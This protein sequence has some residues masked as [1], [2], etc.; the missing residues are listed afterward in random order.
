MKMANCRSERVRG[1][2]RQLAAEAQQRRNHHLYLLFSCVAVAYHRGLDL[3]G[4]ILMNGQAPSRSG[5][6]GYAAR[7]TELE[8]ALRVSRE[9]NPL[10]ANT[11]RIIGINR[12]LKAAVNAF[13]PSRLPLS[14]CCSD[15]A[16]RQMDQ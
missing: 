9:K 15:R 7:L 10:D 14:A 13:Q 1:V 4:G 12:F 16:M 6:N 5:E 3:N 2:D 8:C 11:I